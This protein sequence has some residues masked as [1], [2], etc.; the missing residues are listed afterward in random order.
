M[1]VLKEW[2]KYIVKKKSW[3]CQRYW[4]L[5]TFSCFC[6]PCDARFIV[7]IF[8]TFCVCVFFF[9]RSSV[10][11]CIWKIV[12]SWRFS[13][14]GFVYFSKARGNQFFMYSLRSRCLQKHHPFPTEKKTHEPDLQSESL[15]VFC[16]SSKIWNI[17]IVR[18]CLCVCTKDVK[19]SS[20]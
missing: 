3:K 18:V 17:R 20:V 6:W 11:L 7:L 14:Q 13:N 12:E 4:Y 16:F 10:C 19:Y 5:F 1:Y 9:F 15:Y 8:Q 2:L